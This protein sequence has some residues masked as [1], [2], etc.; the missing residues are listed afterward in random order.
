MSS[1]S[2]F[3]KCKICGKAISKAAKVCPHCGERQR[4]F[5]IIHWVGIVLAS[6]FVIGLLNTPEQPK[7]SSTSF[8]VVTATAPSPK[9]T[10]VAVLSD[11]SQFIEMVE[12][13]SKGFRN[14]KNELQQSALRDQRKTE[15][16]HLVRNRTVSSWVGTI[17]KL[18]TN[19][20]GKAVLYVQISPDIEIKT[21]N[22]ALSDINSNTL[23][24][25]DSELYS[26]LF[27][28][29]R[30]QR[31][32][33]S[34]SFFDSETDY[35]QETSMTIQGSMRSPEFLFKFTSVKSIN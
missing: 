19:S 13:F 22:N 26:S 10:K 8:P 21:W 11:Q 29:S 3:V 20:E 34:G 16:S 15:L 28:L 12:K 24:A 1:E 4:K 7:E 2:L 23:I 6:L 32:E 27:N 17:S 14:A 5:S 9:E 18:D 33:F 30:R 31:V 25:K 35:I